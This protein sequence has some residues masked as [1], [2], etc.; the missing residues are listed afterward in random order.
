[1]LQDKSWC[2]YIMVCSLSELKQCHLDLLALRGIR[3][4]AM[5][6]PLSMTSTDNHHRKEATLH[7]CIAVSAA[8]TSCVWSGSVDY[9]IISLCVN[10]IV[11]I[12]VHVHS[13]IPVYF[14]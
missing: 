10:A 13:M 4:H 7:H 8:L 14:H 11:Y 9:V 5:R 2:V 12:G 6:D 1:M 3:Y